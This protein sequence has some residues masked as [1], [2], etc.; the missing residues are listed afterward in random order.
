MPS[1][2]MSAAIPPIL[3]MPLF[4]YRDYLAANCIFLSDQIAAP[5]VS[6]FEPKSVY[7]ITTEI[8]QRNKWQGV[9]GSFRSE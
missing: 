8:L 4:G 6:I 2:K 5:Y 1:V 3:H 9:S 7:W